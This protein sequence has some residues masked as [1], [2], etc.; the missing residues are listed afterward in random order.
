MGHELEQNGAGIYKHFYTNSVRHIVCSRA[1]VPI[2]R[3][4][5]DPTSP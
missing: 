3:N 2:P 5:F 1:Q 4:D